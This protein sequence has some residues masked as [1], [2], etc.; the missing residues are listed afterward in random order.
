MMKFVDDFSYFDELINK[1]I[2]YALIDVD[3]TIA[4]ANITHLYFFI[5]KKQINNRIAWFLWCLQFA[6]FWAPLYIFLDYLDRDLFQKAFYRRYQEF[7]KNDIEY[8]AEQ[9]FQERYRNNFIPF[10]HDS[11]S[12]LKE[13]GIH[14]T[15]LST[16]MDVVVNHYSRYFD[17]PSICLKM[18]ESNSLATVDLSGINEFKLN[19]AK[20]FDAEK[21]IA[22]ADSKHDLPVLN[23]VAFPLVVSNKKKKWMNKINKPFGLVPE[24]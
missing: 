20:K 13:K 8:Y 22:I 17:V 9:L 19:A 21:T 14:V 2:K 12:Y 15:L 16:N 11:I 7:N 3:N 24:N 4:K 6:C 10:V 18:N 1:G 5:K 23:Y